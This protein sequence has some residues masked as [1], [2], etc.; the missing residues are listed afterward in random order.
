MAMELLE[1]WRGIYREVVRLSGAITEIPDVCECGH[2]EGHL[3]RSCR[4]CTKHEPSHAPTDH[5]ETCTE[6]LTGL[7]AD[8]SLLYEDFAGVGAPIEAAAR[9]THR[10][11]LRRGVF[12]T[13]GDL[14]QILAG[15]DRLSDA[16]VGFRRTCA[17]E[18]MR[19]IKRCSA[20]LRDHCERLNSEIEA[21]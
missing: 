5:G 13:A 11:E 10:A 3:D 6:M 18:E 21:A 2:A 20:S 19:G 14:Q 17:L 8:V 7:R 12:L 4:C 1:Q 9:I 15:L 16:V